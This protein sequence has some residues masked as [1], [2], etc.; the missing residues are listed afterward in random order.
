MK[1]PDSNA[2]FELL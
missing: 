2:N 1:I